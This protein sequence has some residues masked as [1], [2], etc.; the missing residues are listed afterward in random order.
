MRRPGEDTDAPARQPGRG[1]V[2]RK[3]QGRYWLR[4]PG[5]A[6]ACSL[7]NKLR[8]D[9]VRPTADPS[10]LRAH[11]VGVREIRVVDPV[12][13]GDEVEFL[14]GGGGAGMITGVLP[15]RSRI[16]R[17]APGSRPLEQVLVANVDQFVPIFAAAQPP[18]RWNLL[19]RYLATAEAAGIEALVCV[20]K[21]DLAEESSLQ[22]EADMYRRL[23]YR[24]L[25]TSV[26]TGRGLE[27]LAEALRGRVSV[28]AGKSGVGK[29]SLLNALE[30]GLG[31]R[32]NEVSAATGKGKHT[33]T[34][35]EMFPLEDGGFVVD[36]PGVREF[37]L[38]EVPASEVASL[39]REMRPYLGGCRFGA[40]CA[41]LREPGC[42]V[43]DAVAAGE[44]T[45]RRYESY[46]RMR[47]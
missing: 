22:P 15:R 35:L 45:S 33:T 38:W 3:S 32:V 18:P 36:T 28:L 1:T 34:H 40:G 23:G 47:E 41:H 11:V 42:A 31:L 30:P 12:A 16:S 46:R 10:S 29:T 37:G 39:F 5:G 2:F 6:V 43:R 21:L 25:L 20:T 4:T 44:I 8:K 7:S 24:V 17:R 14:P 9:L 26:V 13:V 19:D 27:G